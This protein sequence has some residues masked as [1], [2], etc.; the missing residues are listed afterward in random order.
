VLHNMQGIWGV[1]ERADEDLLLSQER[2]CSLKL[3]TLLFGEFV[4]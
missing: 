3:V 1:G 4:N 2:L